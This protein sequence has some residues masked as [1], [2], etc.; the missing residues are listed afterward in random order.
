MMDKSTSITI[1]GTGAVGSALL[2]V[3]RENG[4]V[5]R[6]EWNSHSG[7]IY[8][9]SLSDPVTKNRSIPQANNE[10]GDLIFITTPDDGISEV[11]E[12]LAQQSINWDGRSV[13][14]CSGNL[15]STELEALKSRGA[16][17]ASMHPIQTFKKGEGK[18][19]FERI[20]TSLEGDD[21]LCN[22]LE[23]LVRR[24]NGKPVRLN[25][26]QKRGLHI[27]AVFSSNYMVALLHLVENY[28][29][30][31]GLDD[32]LNL[33]EPLIRQTIAN[34][35][36]KGTAQSLTGP[37]SRGD[38]ESVQKHLQSLINEDDLAG[39]YKMLG[40][41]ALNIAEKREEIPESNISKL[42]DI[43]KD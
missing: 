24:M 22:R 29:N 8:R 36:E 1:I 15:T 12:K 37:I 11:A 21:E 25:R 34:I 9:D 19:R 3:F 2:N 26:E 23:K 20:Y 35:F 27:A 7:K 33:L 16:Q 43:L 18:E 5:I 10:A 30:E 38:Y 32:G 40:R 17:T 42:R 4:F 39:L 28:L 13:I 14:H 41:E 31:Q 6:S